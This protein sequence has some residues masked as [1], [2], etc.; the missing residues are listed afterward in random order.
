VLVVADGGM[1]N[2]RPVR[3]GRGF[4]GVS[5]I[6]S[7]LAA[8]ERVVVSNAFFLDAERRLRGLAASESPRSAP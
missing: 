2:R 8:G 4:F 6:V 7:G 1:F 3:V 5:A